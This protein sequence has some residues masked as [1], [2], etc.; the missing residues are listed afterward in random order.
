MVYF[1]KVQKGKVVLNPKAALPEGMRVRVEPINP[2]DRK[3]LSVYRLYELAVKHDDL[4]TDLA[5]E[6]DHYLYGLPRKGG[7]RRKAVSARRGTPSAGRKRKR[8]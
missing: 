2:R 4:P 7:R 6:H 1:G 8:A 5:A 3:P